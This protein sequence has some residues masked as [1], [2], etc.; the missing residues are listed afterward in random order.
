MKKILVDYGE[1][2]RLASLF[3]VSEVSVRSALYYRTRSALS[4]RIRQAALKR[5]GK[6]MDKSQTN[7]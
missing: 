5:G 3:R 2:R 7:F 1:K 6:I 4:E